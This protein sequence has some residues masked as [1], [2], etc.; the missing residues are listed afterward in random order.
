MNYNLHQPKKYIISLK[1][2]YIYIC[3][4]VKNFDFKAGNIK[5]VKDHIF[6]NEHTLD[7][8]VVK[9]DHKRFDAT[10]EPTVAWN[11]LQTIT[12]TQADLSGLKYAQSRD[13]GYP[14]DNKF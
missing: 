11:R 4:I 3:D 8:Y 13:D 10:T 12:H 5:N 7:R 6:H 2:C 9:I 1:E 14:Q